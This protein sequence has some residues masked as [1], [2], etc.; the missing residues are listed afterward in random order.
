MHAIVTLLGGDAVYLELP[1]MCGGP[2]RACHRYY[3]WR[4]SFQTSF[5]LRRKTFS[6]RLLHY[7]TFLFSKISHTYQGILTG[8][9]RPQRREG[10][11][12]PSSKLSR[13]PVP[14]LSVP[15]MD[16][17][18]VVTYRPVPLSKFALLYSTVQVCQN[19]L[20]RCT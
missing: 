6:L 11:V 14:S 10:K 3:S 5:R 13:R 1:R 20:L 8:R 17:I 15:S 19:N 2:I 16:S 12:K 7:K 9:E 18:T 4:R